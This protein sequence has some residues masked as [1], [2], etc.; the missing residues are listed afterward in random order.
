MFDL[1]HGVSAMQKAVVLQAKQPS[2]YGQF[3]MKGTVT[4]LGEHWIVVGSPWEKVGDPSGAA[5]LRGA[6]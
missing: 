1:R 3:G 2:Q 4:A 5:L 6:C